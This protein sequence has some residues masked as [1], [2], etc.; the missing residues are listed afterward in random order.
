M[1]CA[2]LAAILITTVAAWPAD[3]QQRNFASGYPSGQYYYPAYQQNAAPNMAFNPSE[4]GP[5]PPSLLNK[6]PASPF[7]P[8]ITGFYY[9][10][11][12]MY[13]QPYY[14]GYYTNLQPQIMW[15]WQNGR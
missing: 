10:P 8:N 2:A 9:R 4:N 13:N 12:Y 5:S 15:H 3:A 6:P 14:N 1:I 11:G 7:S